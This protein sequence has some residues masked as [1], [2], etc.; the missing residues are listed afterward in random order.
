MAVLAFNRA[1]LLMGMVTRNPMR[2]PKGAKKVL[3]IF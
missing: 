2:N 1:I 3:W